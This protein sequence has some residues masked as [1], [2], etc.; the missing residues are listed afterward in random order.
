MSFVPGP[1]AGSGSHP[2]FVNYFWSVCSW[3][4][5]H[6]NILFIECHLLMRGCVEHTPDR[7][8]PRGNGN[9]I[10]MVTIHETTIKLLRVCERG[11]Q[12]AQSWKAR[13][14]EVDDSRGR[15][16]S[17]LAL[18]QQDMFAG[19][20][21]IMKVSSERNKKAGSREKTGIPSVIGKE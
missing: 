14:K 9:G 19:I 15:G 3:C 12:W 20:K 7:A 16:K 5:Y 21:S 13:L 11:L 1:K 4:C 6:H 17:C 2:S 8:F 10:Q 18:K